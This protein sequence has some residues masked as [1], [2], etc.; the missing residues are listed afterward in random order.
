MQILH[1]LL[2]KKTFPVYRLTEKAKNET[3][4]FCFFMLTIY[5]GAN[6]SINSFEHE[7]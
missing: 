5:F 6:R 4:N 7:T 2:Y 3:N 1:L